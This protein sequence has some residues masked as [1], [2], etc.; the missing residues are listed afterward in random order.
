MQ[1]TLLV[2]EDDTAQPS[3]AQVSPRQAGLGAAF[4]GADMRLVKVEN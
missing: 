3:R 2:W 1:R 4:L